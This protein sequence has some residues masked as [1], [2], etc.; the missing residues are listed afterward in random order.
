MIKII[1]ESPQLSGKI[2]V[3]LPKESIRIWWCSIS[4]LQNIKSYISS[5]DDAIKL[6]GYCL[7]SFINHSIDQIICDSKKIEVDEESGDENQSNEDEG[8]SDREILLIEV[9]QTDKKLFLLQPESSKESENMEIVAQCQFCFKV[10]PLSIHCRCMSVSYCSLQCQ[11]NDYRFHQEKCNSMETIEDWD[12]TC[13]KSPEA[14]M[15]LTGLKNLKNSCYMSSSIQCLSHAI[16]LT[17]Y[18][19]KG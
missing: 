7:D 6:K 10:K 16:G 14:R 13:I 18:F 8:K 1:K 3:Q 2:G 17:N 19:L 5:T 4:Q 9:I 15:G 12:L 11:Q